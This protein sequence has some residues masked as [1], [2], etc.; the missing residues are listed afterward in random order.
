MTQSKKDKQMH[1]LKNLQKLVGDF[2]PQLTLTLHHWLQRV[3]TL[4]YPLD[5]DPPLILPLPFP[6]G[7][8]IP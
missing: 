1:H 3:P 8:V 5:K 6:D 7:R 2:Y 4:H